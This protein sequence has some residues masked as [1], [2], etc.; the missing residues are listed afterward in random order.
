MIASVTKLLFYPTAPFSARTTVGRWD[1]LWWQQ[2]PVCEVRGHAGPL[3]GASSSPVC[4]ANSR[5]LPIMTRDLGRRLEVNLSVPW[6]TLMVT[7]T[8][9]GLRGHCAFS[10][11][12]HSADS[13]L[14][15]P[16]SRAILAAG[17]ASGRARG[18]LHVCPHAAGG[19]LAGTWHPGGA[20]GPS[21]DH[22]SFSL[23][24]GC[25]FSSS[26]WHFPLSYMLKCGVY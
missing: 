10:L 8:P 23:P 19:P 11:A 9:L 22:V 18:W 12:S 21:G 25:C 15:Q 1:L 13:N 3:W 14:P 24:T 16:R 5:H 2:C 7:F 26:M 20:A 17:G 4:W 6:F